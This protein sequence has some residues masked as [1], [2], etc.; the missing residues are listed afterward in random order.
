[1]GGSTMHRIGSFV[2]AIL[3]ASVACSLPGIDAT[4]V[5]S[6][7]TQVAATLTALASPDTLSVDPTDA[8]PPTTATPPDDLAPPAGVVELTVVYV[9]G[10]SP[11]IYRPSTGAMQLSPATNVYDV[12]ISDDG[13]LVVFLSQETAG[14]VTQPT[15]IRSIA[16]DGTGEVWLV[17]PEQLNALY[18]LGAFV[19]NDLSSSAFIPGSHDLLLNTRVV[20]E[21]PGLSKYNDLL[22]LNGDSAALTTLL[23]PENGGD[24]SISPDGS[25]VAIVRPDDLRLANTDGTN[26]SASLVNYTPLITYSEYLFYI[27]PMWAPDSSQLGVVVPSA[28]IL[29]ENPTGTIYTITADG[30]AVNAL[31]TFDGD[32]FAVERSGRSGLAP[33]F[34]H[35]ALRQSGPNPRDMLLAPLPGGPPASY[36]MDYSEWQGWAPGGNRFAFST[37]APLNIQLGTVGG[38]PAPLVNGDDLRWISDDQFLYLAGSMGAWTLRLGT[39]GGGTVDIASPAGDFIAYDFIAP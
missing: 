1:M 30:A 9:N 8:P 24:F 7:E 14:G 32:F 5:Q 27:L 18:P 22:R 23:T 2:A 10:G 4:V 38:A 21:G 6:V 29:E 39:V 35:A 33:T 17:T 34:S 13:Q 20:H 26:L 28:D 31:A 19:R 16:A 12:L 11:W 15:G 25:R 37:G 3:L 36:A